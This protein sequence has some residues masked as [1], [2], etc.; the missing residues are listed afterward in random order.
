MSKIQPGV[1]PDVTNDALQ[2][3]KGFSGL[4]QQPKSN[5]AQSRPQPKP[6]DE[7]EETVIACF[8]KGPF[9]KLIVS[10]VDAPDGARFASI[11]WFASSDGL[12]FLPTKKGC[13][14]P[15]RH[16]EAVAAALLD[17]LK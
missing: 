7:H 14:V 13:T 6:G 9:S 16:I 8:K 11:R 15:L 12:T 4:P 2:L 3:P 10:A 1:K 17:V 5:S